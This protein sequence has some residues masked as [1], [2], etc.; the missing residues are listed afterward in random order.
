MNNL[1]MNNLGNIGTM[2]DNPT[3]A[4]LERFL[5]E[6]VLMKTAAIRFQL[7]QLVVSF[8]ANVNEDEVLELE[9][10]CALFEDLED[11][12]KAKIGSRPSQLNPKF[13]GEIPGP[14]LPKKV[15]RTFGVEASLQRVTAPLLYANK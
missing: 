10:L 6:D 15:D 2:D 8:S 7:S 4:E 1:R 9:F 3:I 14:A 11:L 5:A 13:A 12:T